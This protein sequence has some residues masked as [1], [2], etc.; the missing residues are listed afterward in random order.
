MVADHRSHGSLAQAGPARCDNRSLSGRGTARLMMTGRDGT[1]L[2]GGREMR[3]FFVV[4]VLAAALIAP[5]ARAAEH[6]V[7]M[8]SKGPQGQVNWFE[9]PVTHAAPGD[10]IHFVATD[11]RAQQHVPDRPRGRR[12]L[13]RQ[14]EPGRLGD[15]DQARHLCLQ[16]HAP[17]R[18]RDDGA[19][20]GR[21]FR[22]AISRMSR[23]ADTPAR[24]RR[25]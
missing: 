9:P 4:R 8:L 19:D 24:R 2:E 23:P 16:V 13:E 17:F 20:R 7:Q 21:R 3:R 22:R 18:P 14:A 6:E 10:T 11:K 12:D 5:A 1:K 25:R 15:P